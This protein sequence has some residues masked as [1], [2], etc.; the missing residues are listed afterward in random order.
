MHQKDRFRIDLVTQEN[1]E[2]YGM[3]ICD[4][5]GKDFRVGPYTLNILENS[6]IGTPIL[7][8]DCTNSVKEQNSNG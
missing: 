4:D 3:A 7:C 1:E 8:R 5:C 2:D 6:D